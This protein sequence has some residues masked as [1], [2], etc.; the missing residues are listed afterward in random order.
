[1]AGVR[2][3]QNSV[4]NQMDFGKDVIDSWYGDESTSQKHE[5]AEI[6]RLKTQITEL[7]LQNSE[8]APTGAN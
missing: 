5:E 7:E 6:Q 8:G 2:Y 1:M 3:G 4:R